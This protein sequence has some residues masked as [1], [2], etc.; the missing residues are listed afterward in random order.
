MTLSYIGGDGNDVVLT[1][2]SALKTW[3]GN[4]SGNWSDVH[5]WSPQAIPVA[6]EPLVFQ[7]A[8]RIRR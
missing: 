7:P 2:V 8:L 6:G 3:T 5:N 4:V 1:T